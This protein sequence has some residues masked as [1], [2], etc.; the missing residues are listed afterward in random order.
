MPGNNWPLFEQEVISDALID[1]CSTPKSGHSEAHAGLPV[2][3]QSRHRGRWTRSRRG[4]KIFVP[5]RALW[6]ATWLTRT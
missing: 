6:E 1:F 4:S 5:M 3:T 2:L